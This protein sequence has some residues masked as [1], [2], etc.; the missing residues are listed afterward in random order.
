MTKIETSIIIPVYNAEK[1]INK[2]LE[3]VLNQT[4]KNYEVIIINDGSTDKSL[5]VIKQFFCINSVDDNWYIIDNENQGVS[6]SRNEGIIKAK[7]EYIAFLDSDDSWS[8][9]KLEKQLLFIKEKK[10]NI[11]GTAIRYNDKY[12]DYIKYN[13]KDILLS[14]RLCTS[15]VLVKKQLLLKCGLF[16]EKMSYSEDYRLW[17]TIAKIH[18]IYLLNELLTFYNVDNTNGLSS[19]KWLM[20]K[21]E[22]SNFKFL[23]KRGDITQ[24]QYIFYSLI[25]FI[26]YMRRRIK[27]IK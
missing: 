5:D 24:F 11:L 6:V 1:T 4:Y 14:N 18:P 19:K 9:E 27:Q 2:C 15:S 7:G 22:L 20:E 25:S 10:I 16:D 26:K 3:S 13:F 21:G 17:L 23:F 8:E 12:C